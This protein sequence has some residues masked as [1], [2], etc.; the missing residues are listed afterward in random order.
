MAVF[1]LVDC[2]NFYV[3]CQRVFNPALHGRPVIVLSNNDGCVISR[4]AEARHLGIAMGAP[5]FKV[6]AFAAQHNVAVFSSNY[7]LY[8][9]MSQRVMDTLAE[10][11]PDMEVYSIDEA[12]L[13][14]DGLTGEDGLPMRDMEHFGRQIMRRVRQWTGIPVSIGIAGTRTL[15][16]AANSIAKSSARANGLL[17]LDKQ[18][19]IDLAL[20][21][22]P[23]ADV[24]GVGCNYRRFLLSHDI[25]TA[26]EL[27]EA[28]DAWIRRH[29]GVTGHRVVAELRGLSCAPVSPV[30]ATRKALTCSRSFGR[31]VVSAA[32][33]KEAVALYISR[34]AEKLRRQHTFA[35]CLTV[36][37]RTG[38]FR[39]DLPQHSDT[40]HMEL[41]APTDA[42]SELIRHALQAV[43]R[44]FR[45]GYA[46]SKAGVMLTG[47]L[48]AGQVQTSL[49]DSDN[50]ERLRAVSGAVD[51]INRKMGSDTVYHAA[52][53][54][55][56]HRAWNM[57]RDWLSPSYTTRWKDIPV[58]TEPDTGTRADTL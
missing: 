8:A 23:V 50:R 7:A 35:S 41:P 21:R 14:L 46:Y 40:C 22:I 29:M 6:R 4:S 47:L 1:A 9:D 37:V 31:P 19:L 26:Y 20:T 33:L 16:K 38:R 15:A 18:P 43:E 54:D 45:E 13:R 3:S 5:Y 52:A 25:T 53:G 57:R 36:F 56:R 44:I 32:E 49:F 27:C 28:S 17:V 42:T 58:L 48:P 24:W 55:K 11:V 39:D 10:L 2:N 51:S 30:S 12:F 34:A